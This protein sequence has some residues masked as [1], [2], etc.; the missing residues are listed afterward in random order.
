MYVAKYDVSGNVLWAKTTTG[1]GFSKATAIASDDSGNVY[2]TGWFA[3]TTFFESTPLIESTM[4]DFFLAKYDPSGNL[5]WVH[6][7][8]TGAPS[9]SKDVRSIALDN[10]GNIFL[11]GSY[12]NSTI[13]FG[14]FTL[15]NLTNGFD[16]DIFIVKCDPS[17]NPVWA[18]TYGSNV[19]GNSFANAVTTDVAGNY[20]MAGE[21]STTSITFGSYTLTGNGGN[22]FLVKF[23]AA[24]NI[25]WAKSGSGN[26]NY[27]GASGI[28][29]DP[30]GNCYMTGIFS[31]S[32]VT[33]G[34]VTL[35]NSDNGTNGPTSDI[36]LV[37][38]SPSGT[39]AWAR[40]AGDSVADDAGNDISVDSLGNVYIVGNFRSHYLD[41]GTTALTNGGPL[42][43]SNYPQDLLL[44]KYDHSGNFIWAQDPSSQLDDFGTSVVA[45]NGGN[46]YITGNF[47][48]PS[49]VFGPTTISATVNASMYI[50][51]TGSD[52]GINSAVQ[53]NNGISVYPNPSSGIFNLE[54]DATHLSSASGEP[55]IEITDLVGKIILRTTIERNSSAYY[56]TEINLSGNAEGIYFYRVY[57]SGKIIGEGKIIL[58]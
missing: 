33:F 43:N 11:V 9:S 38:Y 36:F 29:T 46:C 2:V 8:G 40:S 21:F 25:V 52:V 4:S 7:T 55:E 32:S 24:G 56:Q 51:R 12:A 13:T 3:D 28:G 16:S 22:S 30:L 41:F 48:G 27:T 37:K 34:S 39:V 26:L 18:N 23:S 15:T 44:A 49:M 47:L 19:N 58:N 10:S 17:G 42:V 20:F 50:A 6:K 57:Y 54:I 45:D 14:S 1:N 53:N 31:D 5:I 35:T